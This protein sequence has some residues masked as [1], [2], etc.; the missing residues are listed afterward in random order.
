MRIRGR[1][2]TPLS[3]KKCIFRDALKF[4]C[5]YGAWFAVFVIYLSRKKEM[6]LLEIEA[7]KIN[8]AN[9]TQNLDKS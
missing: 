9:P 8:A 5:C 2:L 1:E 4:E 3:R 7:M 6:K